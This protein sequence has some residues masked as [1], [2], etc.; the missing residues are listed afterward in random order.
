MPTMPNQKLLQV[1]RVV[2]RTLKMY[3]AETGEGMT[4]LASEAI[5]LRLQQR[6]GEAVYQSLQ[7][8]AAAQIASELQQA[9]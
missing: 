4:D 1:D 9:S 5:A 3:C 2:H 8:R 6:A 7:R